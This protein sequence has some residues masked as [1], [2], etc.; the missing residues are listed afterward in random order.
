M[1]PSIPDDEV[2]E[3]GRNA[4]PAN[5]PHAELVARLYAELLKKARELMANER[6]GHTLQATALVHEAW[7]CI[8][9]FRGSLDEPAFL[10]LAATK[11]RQVLVDHARR[12]KRIKRGGGKPQGSLTVALQLADTTRPAIDLLMLH[13]SLEHLE[14]ID[15]RTAKVVEMRCFS[16]MS[17]EQIARALGTSVATVKRDWAFALGWLQER[18]GDEGDAQGA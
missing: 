13:E 6:P 7:K 14:T 10:A 2:P 4:N 1:H 17:V 15:L 12:R 3:Q 9:E 5:T 11:M 18:L 16:S 8:A